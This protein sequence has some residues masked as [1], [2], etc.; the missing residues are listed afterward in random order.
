MRVE[1]KRLRPLEG[2]VAAWSRAAAV[3]QGAAVARRWGQPRPGEWRLRLRGGRPLLGR[4]LPLA[5]RGGERAAAAREEKA[6]GGCGR[7]GGTDADEERA[8]AA[9]R[10]A[11]AAR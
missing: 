8:A 6:A 3:V 4:G 11:G 5:A 2:S 1:D 7:G 9:G 10:G